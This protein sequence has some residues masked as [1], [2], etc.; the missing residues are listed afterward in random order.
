MKPSTAVM[1][2]MGNTP[3]PKVTGLTTRGWMMRT[4]SRRACLINK[5]MR[6]ILMPPPVEPAHD[7]KQPRNISM[8]G[9]KTGHWA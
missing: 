6:T 4:S 3:P 7:T 1:T 2:D 5:I 8:T 9:A